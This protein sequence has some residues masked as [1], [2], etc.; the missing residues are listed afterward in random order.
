M[1]L[2]AALVAVWLPALS[3]PLRGFLDFS[4]F[5]TAAQFAF[6][7]DVVRL[8]PIVRAEALAGL[9]IAPYLYTPLFALLV[10]PLSWL[11]YQF[12]GFVNLA[13][14]FGAL[15]AAAELGARFYGLPR[16]MAVLGALAWG[17]AG[18]SVLGGQNATFALLLLVITGLLLI[19][20]EARG[21]RWAALLAG[22]AIAIVA[23]KPQFAAPAA[24]LVVL[25][26]RWLTVAATVAGLVAHY[27]LNVAVAGGNF[28]WPVDWLTTLSRYS[29][30]D[31]ETNGRL[32]ISLPAL[33]ARIELPPLT[34]GAPAG[35]QG[36]SLVGYGFAALVILLCVPALRRLP[37]PR[38]LALACSLGLL[39]MPHGW[40]YNATLLLPALAVLARDALD[41]GWPWQ[42]RWLIAAF[43]TIGLLWPIAGLVGFT[44]LP[45]AVVLSPP[46]LLGWRPFPWWGASAAAESRPLNQPLQSADPDS[47]G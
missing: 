13:L 3:V 30:I 31:L 12:A 36:L 44:L 6:T 4:A 7:P 38:A 14:M 19:G 42:D 34:D 32:A 29:N 28:A 22:A 27:L 11:P 10:V 25:R 46:L 40:V 18:A 8:D 23:Y 5:Y 9:P 15:I 24:G 39:I 45:L 47:K 33:F 17:P 26:A 21:S 35:I 20:V 2:A 37:L 1:W 41:R 43:Y 16:R